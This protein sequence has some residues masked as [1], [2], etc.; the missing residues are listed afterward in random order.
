[1]KYEQLF[2]SLIERYT[3]VSTATRAYR[4]RTLIF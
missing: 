2:Y 4:P 1:M 3:R